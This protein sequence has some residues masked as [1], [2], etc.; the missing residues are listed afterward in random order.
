MALLQR[1]EKGRGE[2]DLRAYLQDIIEASV[3]NRSESSRDE[4]G[5]ADYQSRGA[6]WAN[7]NERLA[8]IG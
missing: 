5:I 2:L 4:K 7:R 6:C 8:N 1:R 3:A